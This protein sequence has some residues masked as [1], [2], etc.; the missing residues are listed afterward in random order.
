MT[1]TRQAG[2]RTVSGPAA[3]LRALL[4]LLNEAL[5]ELGAPPALATAGATAM[6]MSAIDAS[7]P[8]PAR[9]SEAVSLGSLPAPDLAEEPADLVEHPADLVD[10]LVDLAEERPDTWALVQR[11]QAGDGEAFGQLYDRYVD[12]VFRFIYFRVNDRML[13]EDFTS[14]TFLRALRRIGTVS[15]Q[16]RDIGAWF[17]TIA[18]N[19]VL[20]HVKSARYRLETPTAEAPDD[21]DRAPSPETAVLD[22]LTAQRLLAAVRS[23]GDEQRDCIVLR[24]IQGFSVRETAAVMGKK[25]GAVKALQHRAVRRLAE[26]LKAEMR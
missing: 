12:A 20:D 7:V 13:A 9:G 3:G 21:G 26:L 10:D 16:G 22:Q 11:A 17:V 5:A 18:R 25:D 8:R 14:E 19:I 2:G 1:R 6:A 23:L 24:F 4:V 15:Y